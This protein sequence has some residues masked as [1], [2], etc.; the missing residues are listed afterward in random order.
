MKILNIAGFTVLWVPTESPLATARI[1]VNAGAHQEKVWGAAHYVEHVFFKGTKQRSY[2]EMNRLVAALGDTN[3][4]T[5]E[6]QT[7]YYI[8]TTGRNLGR[9]FTL[10]CEQFFEATFPQKEIDKERTVILEEWRSGQDNPGQFFFQGAEQKLLGLHPI[11]GTEET[12]QAMTRDHL[13]DFRA[14]FYNRQNVV[15]IVAG[16]LSAVTESDLGKVLSKYEL[17]EGVFNQGGEPT[18]E[19]GTWK[20]PN[21]V[22]FEHTSSQAWLALWSKGQNERQAIAKGWSGNILHDALGG[23]MHSL[24]FQRIRE[25]LGLAYATGAFSIQMKD[26]GLTLTYALLNPENVGQCIMEMQK[27]I[28]R[29]AEDGVSPDLLEVAF[30][31]YEYRTA[32]Q[33]DSLASVVDVLRDWFYLKDHVEPAEWLL[34]HKLKMLTAGRDELAARVQAEAQGMLD[35]LAVSVMNGPK[36]DADGTIQG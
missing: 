34:S 24:L 6:G 17:P 19:F 27:V 13:M 33:A 26:L 31:H 28:Q 3:A 16:D 32:K 7:G 9:A 15:F 23:G 18:V 20:A 8:D 14:E 36:E 10:L 5:S 25:E 4:F 35:G 1:L 11:V 22:E 2:E 21:T 30:S 29:V 12:I